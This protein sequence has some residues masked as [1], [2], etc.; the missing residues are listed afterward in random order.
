MKV[1]TALSNYESQAN[2]FF[3]TFTTEKEALDFVGD[4]IATDFAMLELEELANDTVNGMVYTG[5]LLFEQELDKGNWGYAPAKIYWD[6]EN[7]VAVRVD[8]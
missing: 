1:F 3:G 5:M 2:S 6:K 4:V 8:D 7:C